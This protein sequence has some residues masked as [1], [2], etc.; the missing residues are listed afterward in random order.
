MQAVS[1]REC[2]YWLSPNA[3]I[4]NGGYGMHWLSSATRTK[5]NFPQSYLRVSTTD[6]LLYIFATSEM[7]AFRTL[8]EMTL[9][10]DF[11]T[12]FERILHD[13]EDTDMALP[14]MLLKEI[15][16][17]ATNPLY[18]SRIHFPSAL[19]GKLLAH[20][21]HKQNT[22][23]TFAECAFAPAAEKAFVEEILLRTDKNSGV[24]R[25]FFDRTLPFSSDE[26]S[27]RLLMSENG[28]IAFS[29]LWSGTAY[30]EE[31]LDCLRNSP[32]LQSLEL[33]E[34]NFTS[35][36]AYASFLRSLNSTSLQSLT[37]Q[38]WDMREIAFPVEIF[39]KL[40]LTHFSIHDVCF[41]E[42]GWR[43]LL[44]EISKKCSTLTSLEFK[45]ILW[46]GSD[47]EQ[48]AGGEFALE[49]AQFLKDNPNILATNTKTYFGDDYDDGNDD[50]LY[51]THLAPILEHNR[52]LNNLKGLKE[53][54]NY[55][56][57]GFLVSEAI[58]ALF[59]TKV[60]SCYTMLKANAD[61][62]VSFLPSYN[63]P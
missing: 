29:Y 12:S 27:V 38:N 9:Y 22:S 18:F 59:A 51:T 11:G 19:T 14:T 47:D 56:V 30:S 25:L 28:P 33:F 15:I 5:Q 48:V 35:N 60:S 7:E 44:Q 31:V 37:V 4:T 61:V 39:D 13:D 63:E 62:L 3:F 36:D 23:I 16:E 54:E 21:G 55:E 26:S 20:C 34:N 24:T 17:K 1:S 46:W 53:R 40:A 41:N 43:S 50:I 10:S 49:L 8:Y 58:G 32:R 52:L 6:R 2:I 45:Y 57:R 42:A